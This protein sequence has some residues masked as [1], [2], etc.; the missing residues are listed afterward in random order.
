MTELMGPEEL[1]AALRAIGAVRYHNRHPFHALLHGGKL[2]RGQVRAWA[3]NRYYYQSI[4][5][6]KDAA[7]ISRAADRE[8]RRAWRQRIVDHDGDDSGDG[9]IERWLRLTDALGFERDYVSSGEGL[10]PATRFAVEAY[11]HF[12]RERSLLEA[13]ASSLTELFAPS[14][15][16]ERVSGMLANYDFIGSEALAYFDKRLHQAPRDADFAIEY[17]KREARLPHQQQ[18]VLRA[19]EF[20]CDVLWSQLD[21]LYHAYVA[22]RHV[23][24][25]AYRPEEVSP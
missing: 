5:P 4:I 17:V 15:I 21:A 12:V 11:L 22:P 6:L 2:D 9:G 14:I 3:L 10:L 19:L 1:E 23:P 24:P 7:I 25:G 20:K 16:T 8:F 13:V 18:A